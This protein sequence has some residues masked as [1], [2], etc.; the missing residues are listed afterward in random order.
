MSASDWTYLQGLAVSQF[1]A[2][3][4]LFP[5]PIWLP[6][7]VAVVAAMLGGVRLAP[8][9]FVG[10]FVV[11]FLVFSAS[12]PAATLI[13][14]GN[15]LGPIAGAALLARFRPARG[16]FTRFTG[17]AM[18]PRRRLKRSPAVRVSR[19]SI[20]RSVAWDVVSQTALA[21]GG[22]VLIYG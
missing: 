6:A 3:Y 7:S 1:F 11:N 5:A 20:G 2:V 8:G 10:S 22:L 15:A 14:L 13:S 19:F 16:V 12:F 21:A 9:I 18:V 4:G 17:V